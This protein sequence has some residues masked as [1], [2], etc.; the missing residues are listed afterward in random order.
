MKNRES[1]NRTI[2]ALTVGMLLVMGWLPV[3]QAGAREGEWEGPRAARGETERPRPMPRGG[4]GR[5]PAMRGKVDDWLERFRTEQP[6]EYR[7]LM[8][9]RE[10]NPEA[11]REQLRNHMRDLV[12]RVRGESLSDQEQELHELARQYREAETEAERRR[13]RETLRDGLTELFDD[14]IRSQRERLEDMR[15]RLEEVEA[16][17]ERREEHRDEIIDTRVDELLRDPELRW[18]MELPQ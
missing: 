9:L 12:K 11:F 7:E 1:T 16:A 10:T 8:E 17:I 15:A 18:H 5:G 13:L 2:R 6:E 14:R 3:V 4:P